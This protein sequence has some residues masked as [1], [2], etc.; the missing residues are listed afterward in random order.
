MHWPLSFGRV[1]FCGIEELAGV[2]VSK[3]AGQRFD[4]SERRWPWSRASCSKV[5]GMK[6]PIPQ[7]TKT[8]ARWGQ[9]RRSW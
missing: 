8:W 5:I 1:E 3:E 2:D 7:M 4:L 6:E 9:L